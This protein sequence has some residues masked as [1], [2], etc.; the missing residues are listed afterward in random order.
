MHFEFDIPLTYRWP[1]QLQ[2]LFGLITLIVDPLFLVDS[3]GWGWGWLTG[4]MPARELE[5]KSKL[6]NVLFF[7]K[8]GQLTTCICRVSV[9]FHHCHFYFTTQHLCC[10]TLIGISEC[11]QN[12]CFFVAHYFR[13]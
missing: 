2:Y 1:F 11:I 6:Q 5:L 3:L 13:L 4:E 7:L 12:L 8:S 10:D 9:L